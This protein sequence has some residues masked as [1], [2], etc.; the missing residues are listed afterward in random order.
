L[1]KRV[2]SVNVTKG[3]I[4]IPDVAKEKPLEGVVAAV[5]KGKRLKN[6]I[7]VEPDLKVGDR[8]FFGKYAGFEM[9]IDDGKYIMM[10][11]SDVLCKIN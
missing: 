7:T 11:D 8:I 10:R 5:G 3:G 6:G 9:D 1:V 4:I 2:E